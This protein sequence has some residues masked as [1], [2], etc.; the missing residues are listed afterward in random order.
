MHWV[1]LRVPKQFKIDTY[2]APRFIHCLFPAVG[3]NMSS[4]LSIEHPITPLLYEMLVPLK[5]Y[6]QSKTLEIQNL[7]TLF[8]LNIMFE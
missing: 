8:I 2:G 5:Q 4:R 1:L 7:T 3:V 6:Y